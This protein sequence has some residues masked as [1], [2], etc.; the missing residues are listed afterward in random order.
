MPGLAR[1]G[2]DQQGDSKD[3]CLARKNQGCEAAEAIGLAAS[4]GLGHT[5]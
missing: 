3:W 4:P 1:A 5:K 2:N